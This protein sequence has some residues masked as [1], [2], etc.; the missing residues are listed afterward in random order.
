MGLSIRVYLVCLALLRHSTAIMI[1]ML[2]YATHN[3]NRTNR[4]QNS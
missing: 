3:L 4:Y 2:F 1:M